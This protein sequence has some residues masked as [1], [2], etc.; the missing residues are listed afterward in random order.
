MEGEKQEKNSKTE[1]NTTLHTGRLL[2]RDPGGFLS[3]AS[4]RAAP[5]RSGPARSPQNGEGSSIPFGATSAVG[6]ATV[7]Q[8][9]WREEP[10]SPRSRASEECRNCATVTY[11]TLATFAAVVV[12]L[13]PRAKCRNLFTL[14]DYALS[15]RLSTYARAGKNDRGGS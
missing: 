9:P 13:D 10:R 4:L 6:T 14:D 5:P 7:V 1:V 3:C 15:G 8:F 2:I 11:I 12:P